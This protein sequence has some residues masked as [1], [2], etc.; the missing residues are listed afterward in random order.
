MNMKKFLLCASGFLFYASVH[1]TQQ[2]VPPRPAVSLDQLRFQGILETYKAANRPV[3]AQLLET[4]YTG[5][6]YLKQNLSKWHAALLGEGGGAPPA[7]GKAHLLH[8]LRSFRQHPLC[9]GGGRNRNL[10][11][12]PLLQYFG[13][14]C[15]GHTSRCHAN[16]SSTLPGKLKVFDLDGDQYPVLIFGGDDEN[17][18]LVCLYANQAGRNPSSLFPF[19]LEGGEL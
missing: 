10:P 15:A 18:A 2:E 7:R 12:P 5:M 9:H 16:G 4:V 13:G 6:C 14:L 3:P 11:D 19:I 17:V 8:R 1:S